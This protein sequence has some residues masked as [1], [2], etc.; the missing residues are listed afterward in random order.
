MVNP[1]VLLV[2]GSMMGAWAWDRLASELEPMGAQCRSFDLPGHGVDRTP[3]RTVTTATYIRA[4]VEQID[5]FSSPV[6]LVGHS[7]AGYPI[8]MAAQQRPGQVRHLV[9][10]SAQARAAGQTWAQTLDPDIRS[11][12]EASAAASGDG[13]YTVPDEIVNSRWL[14]SVQQDSGLAQ[15][16]RSRLTPQPLAPLF[17]PAELSED[18]SHIPITYLWPTGDRQNTERRMRLSLSNLPRRTKLMKIS[19]DHC[20]MLTNPKES[21]AA[22]REIMGS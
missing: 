19:G 9:Y 15:S 18:L 2:H 12:Y 17:E 21:A 4:I 6:L 11:A 16:I 1:G 10:F 14:T 22:R 7:M 3:R 13:S 8:T 5:R 20:A